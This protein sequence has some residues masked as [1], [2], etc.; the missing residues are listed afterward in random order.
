MPCFFLNIIPVLGS[1]MQ[2]H[3]NAS[4]GYGLAMLHQTSKL[5]MLGGFGP[6]ATSQARPKQFLKRT[7]MHFFSATM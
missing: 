3:P 6:L 2:G 7:L 5:K 1:H 4:I